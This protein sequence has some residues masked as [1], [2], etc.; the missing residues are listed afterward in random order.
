M[1]KVKETLAARSRGSN[2][3]QKTM[4]SRNNASGSSEAVL[5]G[6]RQMDLSKP[7]KPESVRVIRSITEIHFEALKRLADR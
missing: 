2:K 6:P 7:A 4:H 1:A 5:V 3:S